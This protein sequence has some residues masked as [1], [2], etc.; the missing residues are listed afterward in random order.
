VAG[1][2][3]GYIQ[4]IATDHAPHTAA[5]KDCDFD[6]AAFGISGLETALGSVMSLVH[7]GDLELSTLIARLT[8]G[9]ARLLRRDDIG[10]LEPGAEGDVCI[11]DPDAEWEVDPE[12]FESKG[13]NTPLAGERLKG[14]VMATVYG[15]NI[16]YKDDAIKLET[17]G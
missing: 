5:D 11:F 10:T 17:E 14:K 7:S 6:K 13:R 1:L 2:R 16:V 12:K 9:P 8:C 15:G 4:A 3:D